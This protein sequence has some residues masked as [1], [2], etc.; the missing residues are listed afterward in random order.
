MKISSHGSETMSH[1]AD[2]V[3]T[4]HKHIGNEESNVVVTW[5]VREDG[6]VRRCRSE[7]SSLRPGG[8]QTARLQASKRAALLLSGSSLVAPCNE[9]DVCSAEPA[10][11][12]QNRSG[13]LRPMLLM[14]IVVVAAISA[15]DSGRYP[16]DG[17]Y[18]CI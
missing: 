1:T 15:F 11:P 9:P 18:H 2:V 8:L 7:F 6:V 3:V 10:S 17:G 5:T 16:A 13:R 4:E 14:S 12:S